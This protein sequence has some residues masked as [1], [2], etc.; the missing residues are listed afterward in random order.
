MYNVMGVDF[1]MCA[2]LFL[3]RYCSLLEG[4][5]CAM[6]RTE[7]IP[8]IDTQL[9]LLLQV[10]FK[11]SHSLQE[12]LF[13]RKLCRLLGQIGADGESV[14]DVGEKVELIGDV[15]LLEDVLRLATLGGREDVIGF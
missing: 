10:L 4:L 13:L 7:E 5:L 2:R 12:R 6:P 11:P 15:Q 3:C 9:S 8:F 14:L 1:N